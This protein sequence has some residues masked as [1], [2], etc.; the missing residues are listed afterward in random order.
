MYKVN[1]PTPVSILKNKVPVSLRTYRDEV[2]YAKV[3][4]VR[5]SKDNALKEEKPLKQWK[6]WKLI[7]N[8]FPYSSAFKIHHLLV[9][10]RVVSESELNETERKEL[11]TI[12]A[13]VSEDYDCLLV[14]FVSKQSIRNH[15]HL[16]LLTYKDKR[17][18]LGK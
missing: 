17:S 11:D 12:L 7:I 15:F 6:H 13:E 5:S 18:E 3:K 1:I 14:N 8:A 2:K 4:K 16:H 10:N 9:P